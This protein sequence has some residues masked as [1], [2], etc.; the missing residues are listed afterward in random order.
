M[1]NQ[2][3]A[4]VRDA[5]TRSLLKN[6]HRKV[7]SICRLFT[8][9]YKEHQ[10]LFSEVIAAATRSIRARKTKEEPNTLLIR[11]CVNMAVLHS[12][13]RDLAPASDRMTQF[14]SP[15]FQ[16]SMS[17]LREKVESLTDHEK[18]LLFLNIEKADPNE[19]L[20]RT[21]APAASPARKAAI[22]PLRPHLKK[23]WIWI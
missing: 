18:I 3:N 10:T 2:Q 11:A 19:V 16:K 7:Y 22:L 14:K 23:K 21:A 9:N 12:I 8:D 20:G 1:N 17:G 4:F 6:N 5:D 15:D 13:S